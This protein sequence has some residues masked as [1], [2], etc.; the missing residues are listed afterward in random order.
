MTAEI[1]CIH[2]LAIS[3]IRTFANRDLTTNEL[4][5]PGNADPG[6]SLMRIVIK[7]TH[8]EEVVPVIKQ[9]DPRKLVVCGH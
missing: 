9:T 5:E 4:V 2:D 7:I 3:H 6:L 1:V 8:V